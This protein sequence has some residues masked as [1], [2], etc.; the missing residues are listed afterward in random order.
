MTRTSEASTGYEIDT[1]DVRA[2][3]PVVTV[4]VGVDSGPTLQAAVIEVVG[5]GGTVDVHR[6]APVDLAFN[7]LA[8]VALIDGTDT[9]L[10]HTSREVS[11]FN[12][13][14]DGVGHPDGGQQDGVLFSVRTVVVAVRTIHSVV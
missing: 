3:Y 10:V 1:A 8:A 7:H 13:D 6:L 5:Q 4:I 14:V 12:V 9:P 11:P 2:K